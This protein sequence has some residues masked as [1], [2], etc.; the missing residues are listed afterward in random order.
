MVFKPARCHV[1]LEKLRAVCIGATSSTPIQRMAN[2]KVI[3]RCTHAPGLAVQEPRS[4]SWRDCRDWCF[5][6][7]AVGLFSTV[8][9]C[10]MT[11]KGAIPKTVTREKEKEGRKLGAGS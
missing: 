3:Q 10:V 4:S 7:E 9:N 5:A 6:M 8:A 11:P 1:C 2:S